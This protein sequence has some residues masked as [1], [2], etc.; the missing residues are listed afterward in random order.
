ML[1]GSDCCVRIILITSSFIVE[2][3]FTAYY[4]DDR[5]ELGAEVLISTRTSGGLLKNECGWIIQ[6]KET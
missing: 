3:Q 5:A 1:S 6:D 4:D 2:K